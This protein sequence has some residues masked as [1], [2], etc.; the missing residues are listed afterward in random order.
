MLKRALGA[1]LLPIALAGCDLTTNPFQIQLQFFDEYE[2]VDNGCTLTFHATAIGNGFAEW[3]RFT[4]LIG[5][6]TV[7]T[8]TG[9]EFWGASR[10]EAGQE[11]SSITLQQPETDGQY[12]VLMEFRTGNN[13]RE[14]IFSADCPEGTT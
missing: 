4:H 14:L 9:T 2:T 10:I 6:Q 13:P 11:Q 7:A 5:N 1:L 3:E 8:Y 12:F